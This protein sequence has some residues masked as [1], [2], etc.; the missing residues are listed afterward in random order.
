MSAETS[1]CPDCGAVVPA[2]ETCIDSFHMMG[3]WELEYLLYDVH[4][5]MVVCYYLQ[6]PH[7]Y[8]PEGLESVKTMLVQ[9]VEGDVTPQEMRKRNS[10]IVD[11]SVRKYKI[12][13]TPESH[14]QYAHLVQW[15]IT[16]ADVVAAGMDRYYESVR[17][18]AQSVLQALRDSGNLAP[19]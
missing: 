7:L 15:T 6:H 18:W 4:H 5:L 8:S 19:G 2:G 13:G 1:H 3:Y 9:F 11:S 12:A 10:K 14:G 17:A 16:A